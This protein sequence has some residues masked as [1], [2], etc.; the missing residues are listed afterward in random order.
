VVAVAALDVAAL[1]LV[2]YPQRLAVHLGHCVQQHVHHK[3]ITSH[4]AR[5]LVHH[6]SLLHARLRSSVSSPVLAACT[7]M[8]ASSSRKPGR[9]MLIVL[10]IVVP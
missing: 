2:W 9:R 8:H 1:L 3:V 5:L 4:T 10:R 7:S 6:A